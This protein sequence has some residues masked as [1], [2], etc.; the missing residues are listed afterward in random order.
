M[1][2]IVKDNIMPNDFQTYWGLEGITISKFYVIFS[3]VNFVQNEQFT[4]ALLF[5]T[6]NFDKLK[7]NYRHEFVLYFLYTSVNH[8]Y[9]HSF[10]DP[11]ERKNSMCNQYA[12]EIKRTNSLRS[13]I[14]VIA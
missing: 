14:A 4:H 7:L 9:F 10:F 11:F 12:H 1:F 13:S 6:F 2:N 5:L 3:H 8:I